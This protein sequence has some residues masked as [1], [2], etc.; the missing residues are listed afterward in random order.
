MRVGTSTARTVL[1]L[2]G[3]VLPV[4]ARQGNGPPVVNEWI[5]EPGARA[6]EKGGIIVLSRGTVRTTRLYSDFVLRFEFRQR[7]PNAEARVLVRS[8]FNYGTSERGYRVTLNSR[9][10]G[11]EALGRIGVAS[12]GMQHAGFAPATLSSSPDGWQDCEIRAERDHLTIT[13]NGGIVSSAEHL[14]EFTGYIA[15]QAR[16]EG[17]EFRNLHIERLPASGAPFGRGAYRAEEADI[18]RPR[19]TKLGKP[20]YPRAPHDEWIQGTV[21]LEAL[22]EPNGVVGDVRVLKSVH[23]DLDEAAIASARQSR[24]QPGRKSGKDVAVIVEI[25]FSFERTR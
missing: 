15:L 1:V 14:D 12:V 17:I 9:I 7:E 20:F 8:R 13:I 19:P 5:A 18:I 21:R 16:R 2:L 10:E 25:E 23:P 6:E 3:F 4:A 24:F 11:A 22:I